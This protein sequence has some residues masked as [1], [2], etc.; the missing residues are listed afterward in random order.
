MR[1]DV[2]LE[3]LRYKSVND[4]RRIVRNLLVPEP[5]IKLQRVTSSAVVRESN[6]GHR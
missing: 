2:I 1:R 5:V 4:L 3:L 6:R